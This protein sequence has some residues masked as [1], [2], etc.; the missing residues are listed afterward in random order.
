MREYLARRAWDP[1][2]SVSQGGLLK[3]MHDGEY[4]MYNPDVIAMLQSAVM[5][6]RLCAVPSSSPRWSTNGRSPASAIC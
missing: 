6:G 4:H 3:Y 1:T 5:T 2:E